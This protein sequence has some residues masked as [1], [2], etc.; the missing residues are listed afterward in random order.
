MERR[1]PWKRLSHRLVYKTPWMEVYED[2][3]TRPDGSPGQ[4]SYVQVGT[5]VYIVAIT[6]DDKIYLVGQFRYPTSTFSWEL[7][8]GAADGDDLLAEAKR[9]LKEETGLEAKNWRKIGRLQVVN[10]ISQDWSH[11]FIATGLSQTGKHQQEE[12]GIQEMQAFSLPEILRMIDLGELSCGQSMA[13]LMLA[14]KHLGLLTQK[15]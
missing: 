11:V 5:G 10:G 14:A 6:D 8:A 12:E 1:N 2:K 3:V 15:E 7:P 4:Y 13:A 9:E